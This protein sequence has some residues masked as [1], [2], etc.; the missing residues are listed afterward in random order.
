[1]AK[2]SRLLLMLFA[3]LALACSERDL[4]PE[5]SESVEGSSDYQLQT[6]SC[7]FELPDSH[8]A[9]CAKLLTPDESGGFSLPV[10][11]LR[12]SGVPQ[13]GMPLLYLAGG[14]G[15][16]GNISTNDI[17]YWVDWHDQAKLQGDL[18]LVDRRGTGASTP[19]DR[20]PEYW[21][22]SRDTLSRD[23]SLELELTQGLEVLKSCLLPEDAQRTAH[24]PHRFQLQHYGSHHSRE[25]LYALMS[26][27]NYKQWNVYG[28]SYGT[29]LA[30]RLL[31]DE[32]S[33]RI[34]RVVLDSPYPLNKGSLVEWPALQD[35]AFQRLFS[36]QPG[37]E[38][39][40]FRALARLKQAPMTFS[41]RS[42]YG[43]APMKV[44]LNDHRLLSMSYSSLY[45]PYTAKQIPA[46]VEAV[47]AGRRAEIAALL[48][49]FI[50]YAFDPEFNPLVYFALECRESPIAEPEEYTLAV[51]QHPR[52]GAYTKDLARFDVCRH[53]PLFEPEAGAFQSPVLDQALMI[54]AGSEDPITPLAWARELARQYPEAEL[55]V[56][57]GLGH[58]LVGSS[59]EA[60]EHLGEFL[61]RLSH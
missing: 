42:W 12:R 32:R 2:I 6:V 43:D 11:V 26:A 48:E 34:S 60:H 58:S 35:E 10:V 61:N 20:C 25:D 28:V 49:P 37:L 1:M 45:D 29:R 8:E 5:V 36:A 46:A 16:S 56:Y 38:D 44:V 50:N 53:L 54:M 59:E 3:A 4:S 18:V 19:K 23:V 15:G 17:S 24:S 21:Q 47:L 57:E 33:S 9:N 55:R 14:P 51:A 52:L 30:L 41:V 13:T 27:L 40:F 39:N 31:Q 22:F 7:W